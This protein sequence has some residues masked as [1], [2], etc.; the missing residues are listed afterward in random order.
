M[1]SPLRVPLRGG[2]ILDGGR[3]PLR[4]GQPLS[5]RI[6]ALLANRLG[7]P[8][9]EHALAQWLEDFHV[10]NPQGRRWA[11]VWKQSRRVNVGFDQ[12]QLW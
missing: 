1:T 8:G 6:F 10:C 3:Q 12:W 5:E 4:H 7:R 9:S 11:P 2:S